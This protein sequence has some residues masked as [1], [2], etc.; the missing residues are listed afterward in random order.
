VVELFA[1][2]SHSVD[3][4]KRWLV[5]AGIDEGRLSQSPNKQVSLP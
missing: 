1:P 5:S 4:V 2:R 3:K